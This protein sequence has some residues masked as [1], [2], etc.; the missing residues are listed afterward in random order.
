MKNCLPYFTV[1]SLSG[2]VPLATAGELTGK[3][4]LKGTPKPEVEIPLGDICGKLNPNKVTTRHY[5]VGKDGGLANVFVYL[6]DAKAAPATGVEPELDQL[7]CMY[8]PYVMGVVAGQK[9]K[10]KNSDATL[11]NVHA[12]PKLNKE[13]NIGQPLKGQVTEKTFDQPEVLVRMKCDVHPWMFAYIGV[14]EH[15]YFA[16][17]DKEGNFKIS[18]VPDGKYT[19]VAYHLKTHGANA[20][21]TQSVEVKGT[22]KQDFT[23]EIPAAP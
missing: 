10:V 4:T 9:F 18:G 6:K 3:V 7:G 23:V 8:E 12:T 2:F 20:G 15:P 19:V 16:V 5:V 1:A 21:L 11:H 17:T 13:F 14:V 22:A